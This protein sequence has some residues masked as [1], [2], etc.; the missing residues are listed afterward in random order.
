MK[1]ITIFLSILILFSTSA[2]CATLDTKNWYLYNGYSTLHNFS[3]KFP[4]DCKDKIISDQ[5][6][7]FYPN[8]EPGENPPFVI[9][10]FDGQTFKQVTT[11]YLDENLSLSKEN[12]LLLKLL[13]ED[14]IAKQVTY[15]NKKTNE[16]ASKLFI[17]RGSLIIVLSKNSKNYSDTLEAIQNSFKFN[18][19]WHQYIDFVE[20]YSFIFPENFEINN[21]SNGVEI[22]TKNETIFSIVKYQNTSLDKAAKIA[23]EKNEE[24]L[25]MEDLNIHGLKGLEATY[26]NTDENKKLSKIFVEKNG[27]IYAFTGPNIENSFPHSDY[28]NDYIIE[29]VESFEFFNAEIEADYS[30]FKY[31]PDVRENHPNAVSINSL[32]KDKVINGY[33]DGTF[34]PDGEISRAELTKMVVATKTIP[35]AKKYN[36]CFTD[37][38]NEWYAPYICYAK[39]KGWVSGYKDGK[40]KPEA[41]INRAESIKIVLE[42]FFSSKISSENLKNTSVTDVTSSDWFYKYFVYS[43]NRN[44]LDKQHIEEKDG[45][46]SYF[47][48]KNITRKEIAELIYRAKQL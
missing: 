38:K 36:N 30:T 33:T 8:K 10:E 32:V 41:K 21:L 14:V 6:Q 13:N 2:F 27:Q 20:G 3:V 46:Y 22:S 37:I 24:Y 17:K 11:Y 15:I 29:M 16:E 45:K 35:D 28:S 47:P 4:T 1:K 40:F 39:E 18:D 43:D 9:E 19:G 25:S 31:F 44:L 23:G 12:D 26:R 5:I 7:V 34:K 48:G 42:F